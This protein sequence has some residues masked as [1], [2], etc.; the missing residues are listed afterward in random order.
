VLNAFRHHRVSRTMLASALLWELLCAQRLSASQSFADSLVTFGVKACLVLNAF[1][2]HRVSRPPYWRLR[3]YLPNSAQRL[4]ASQSFAG[5]MLKRL[6]DAADVL[7]A[8]R[9]HR[10]SRS[11]STTHQRSQN[12]VLNAFRHH[13]VSR[14]TDERRTWPIV[15]CSTPFGITEFRGHFRAMM[16]T[17]QW[18]VLNAFRHHRV[19]RA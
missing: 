2:H 4:S 6:G 12:L 13:R 16:A 8:F 18:L 9:H 11:P 1:R 7:N 17:P 3:S 5:E 10:V 14:F 15:M 19:S